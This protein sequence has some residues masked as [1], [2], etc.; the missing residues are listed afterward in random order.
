MSMKAVIIAGKDGRP[1]ISVIKDNVL[2]GDLISAFISALSVFGEE[3][4]G[5]IEEI[6]IKGLDIDLFIVYR[7]ELILIAVMESGMK[8][9]D[10]RGE[11]EFALDSFHDYYKDYLKN[12][13]GDQTIFKEFT[14]MLEKQIEDYYKKIE[15]KNL[16]S[17]IRSFF[18]S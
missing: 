3:N 13:D 17:R 14:Q 18:S 7:H 9:K 2:N 8:K 10:I 4:L 12:W 1:F 11:A 6:L 15:E 16:F 5:R